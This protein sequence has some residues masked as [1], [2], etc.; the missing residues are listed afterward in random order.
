MP[1]RGRGA[2]APAAAAAAPVALHGHIRQWHTHA[3][4]CWLTT[5]TLST[6]LRR[7]H[8]TVR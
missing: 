3:A 8:C 2:G 6:I 1:L 7:R 5:K 4:V